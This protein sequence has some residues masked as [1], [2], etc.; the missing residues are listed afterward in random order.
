[1]H[2]WRWYPSSKWYKTEQK[3]RCGIWRTAV[4]PPDAAEKNRNIGAQLPSLRCTKAPK[5]FGKFTSCMTFQAQ[6]LVRS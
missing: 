4:A 3:M 5:I 6:K 1:M 2:N